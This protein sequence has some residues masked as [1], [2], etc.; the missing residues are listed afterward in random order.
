MF[1]VG[2]ADLEHDPAGVVV[3]AHRLVQPPAVGSVEVGV[4]L[5][6]RRPQI[7]TVGVPGQAAR[8]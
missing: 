2:A 7:R 8:W 4:L 6:K 3:G 1:G 5:D